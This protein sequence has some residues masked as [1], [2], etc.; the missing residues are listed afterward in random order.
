MMS[1]SNDSWLLATGHWL[2]AV[3]MRRA[4]AGGFMS[5]SRHAFVPL[6]P[7][8]LHGR[9]VSLLGPLRSHSLFGGGRPLTGRTFMS[10]GFGLPGKRRVRGGVRSFALQG[11]FNRA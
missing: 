9:L 8:G 3:R 1:I 4:G 2:L 5:G 11:M 10:G 7:H 6:R